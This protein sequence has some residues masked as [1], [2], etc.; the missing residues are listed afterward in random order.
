M[1]QKWK[2]RVPLV[3]PQGNFGS[4]DPDPPAAM[5]YTE[6]RMTHAAMDMLAR[7]SN[8]TRWIS[9]PTTTIA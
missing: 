4:I 1:A 3:D 7:T 5:R 6:A 8:S 2:M 9:S